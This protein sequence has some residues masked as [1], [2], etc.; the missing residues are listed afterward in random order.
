MGDPSPPIDDCNGE[1]VAPRASAGVVEIHAAREL[2]LR[3]GKEHLR[4]EQSRLQGPV[5]RAASG[6]VRRNDQD[7]RRSSASLRGPAAPAQRRLF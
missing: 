2:R 7:C 6:S 5:G 3:S 1:V 4:A